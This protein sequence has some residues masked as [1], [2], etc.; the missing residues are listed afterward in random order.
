[1]GFEYHSQH[2]A[3]ILA[4]GD[5]VRLQSLTSSLSGD[6]RPKQ[7][8]RLLGT[9]TLLGETRHRLAGTVAPDRTVFVVTRA[10][11]A[12]YS[13][14]LCDVDAGRIYAQPSNRG[15]LAAVL[16]TLARLK[17]SGIDGVVGFFP[18]DHHYR[19]AGLFC[20]A[21]SMAYWQALRRPERVVLLGAEATHPET[22]YGWIEPGVVIPHQQHA[23]GCRWSLRTVERFVEKPTARD[24]EM[25]LARGCLWNTLVVVGHID[26]ISSLVLDARPDLTGVMHAL[27]D[28]A[29]DDVSGERMAD[30][31]RELPR[32]D[33]SADALAVTPDRLMVMTVPNLGWTD[34]GR[35]ERVAD[36]LAERHHV[37]TGKQMVG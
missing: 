26:A 2:W 25:L 12:Y 21:V 1:M 28:A 22:D 34:L 6:R 16:F 30:L 15:T 33:F 31:Y 17:A 4:G 8:C 5:G 29:R 10:H 32:A 20:H 35:P 14:E 36:V 13:E 23:A 27:I 3:A 18:C 37:L 7:Y 19:E 9:H 24:A 11:E